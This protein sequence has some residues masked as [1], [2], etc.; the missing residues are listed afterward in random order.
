M[1]GDWPVW[2]SESDRLAWDVTRKINRPQAALDRARQAEENRLSNTK[3]AKPTP[4]LTFLVEPRVMDGGAL[5]TFEEWL[6]DRADKNKSG[7]NKSR[8]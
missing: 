8:E 2:I 3:G 4:G 6:V 7:Q 5:P 1:Q